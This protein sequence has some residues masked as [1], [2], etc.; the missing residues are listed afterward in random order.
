MGYNTDKR[1]ALMGYNTGEGNIRDNLSY[2]L[3]RRIKDSGESQVNIAAA[4]GISPS[5]LSSYCTGARYPR[6]EQLC[7]L[8]D[9]FGISVGELT[10]DDAIRR[11]QA[12]RLSQEATRI[13]EMFDELDFHGRSLIRMV[14]EAE[15]RRVREE[16]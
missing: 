10:D 9:Y 11:R 7:A 3:A 8:A 12:N 15:L 5:A 13:A 4:T 2:N 1:N 6:P 14:V 16:K